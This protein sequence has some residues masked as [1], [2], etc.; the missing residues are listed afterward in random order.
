MKTK[1]I[2]FTLA[3]GISCI[4][5]FLWFKADGVVTWHLPVLI[6]TEFMAGWLGAD[7]WE[8]L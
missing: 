2:V 6:I 1:F 3:F 4:V 7:I 5:I 8:A